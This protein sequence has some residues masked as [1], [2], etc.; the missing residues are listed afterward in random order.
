MEV[1]AT[2]DVA[3][4]TATKST[5]LPSTTQTPYNQVRPQRR[6][7]SQRPFERDIVKPPLHIL[8]RTLLI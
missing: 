6:A 1:V 8:N 3:E 2:G 7:F 5:A 4:W